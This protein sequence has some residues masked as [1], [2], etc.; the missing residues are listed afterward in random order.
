MSEAEQAQRRWP[1]WALL[2]ATQ[3]VIVV[4]ACPL[5][6]LGVWRGALALPW[7]EQSLGG[8]RLVGYSTWNAGCEPYSGCAP[9][10]QESYV[11]WLVY[12]TQPAG[13]RAYRLVR[14]PIAH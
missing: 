11:V 14:V 2:V 6:G 7:F 13:K 4:L 1:G 10:R 9:P 8:A 3:L 12:E 5:A